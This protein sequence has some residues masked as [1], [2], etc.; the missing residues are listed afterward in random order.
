[1][2]TMNVWLTIA[3]GVMAPTTA[4]AA[5]VFITYPFEVTAT[6]GP[7]AGVTAAG[8]FTYDTA[9]TPTGGG[10]LLAV[11]LLSDLN[12]T[13]DSITYNASTANTGWLYLGSAGNFLAGGFG[14]NCIAGGC[15]VDAF[16]DQWAFGDVFGK[17][18]FD[19]AT[20]SSFGYPGTGVIG[21][22]TCTSL[23]GAPVPCSL[24]EP[25]TLALFGVGLAG[26][27]LA[28]RKRKH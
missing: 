8:T 23:S 28:R 10:Q 4:L 22:P 19:Y 2:R 9:I 5:P 12:F 21:N 3:A 25:A 15:G 24:P 20:P 6:S 14:T 13:W 7:L 11:G 18:D 17:V 27:G 16:T 1:M 26:I